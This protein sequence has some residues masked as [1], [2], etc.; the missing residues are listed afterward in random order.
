MK[1]M[2]S[3]LFVSEMFLIYTKNTVE[4]RRNQAVFF[5]SKEKKKTSVNIDMLESTSAR[6]ADFMLC[7]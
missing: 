6:S 7:I 2:S 1:I 4:H 5:Q 3:S